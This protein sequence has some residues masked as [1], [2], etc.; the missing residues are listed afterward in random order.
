[1]TDLFNRARAALMECDPDAKCAAVRGL[2]RDWNDGLSM[3]D[4][5][6]AA[7]A[8][9]NPGRPARPPLV[10]PR[11]V[12]RRKVS[13]PQGRAALLHSLAH[14]EFNAVNLALDA[15]YRFRDLP[16]EYYGDWIRVA[17]E[18]A[19]HFTL[20]RDHLCTLG[21]DYGS[22]S[23]HNG[24]WEMAVKTAHDPLVRM[25][26]VPRLLEARGLDASPALIAKL[27]ACGDRRAAEIMEIIRR[28]EIEHV[29]IG[30]RWYAYLCARRGVDALATFR[31]LLVAHG[32]RMRTPFD[33]A[34]RRRA[35]FS[36]AEL[37][38][39]QELAR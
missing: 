16:R 13:T 39:I 10:S 2:L 1:M 7:V 9:L 34:A 36:E 14:I 18:E 17:T 37:D 4:D 15:L 35:G 8:V 22:F 33:L 23:A 28:D 5:G 19:H 6:Q 27:G 31:H 3:V 25:A 30:N 11:A 21:F 38:L 29:R 26:L 20:L 24:L 12:E 32:A